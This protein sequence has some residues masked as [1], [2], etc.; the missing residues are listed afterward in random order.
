ML[1]P[2]FHFRILEDFLPIM[3][4]HVTVLIDI[5]KQY[6]GKIID[7][8]LPFITN[9]TLDIICGESIKSITDIF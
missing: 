4:E 8:F 7:D 6:D 5:L 3:N 1:T 2:S 9:C